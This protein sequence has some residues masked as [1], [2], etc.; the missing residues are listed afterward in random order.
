MRGHERT[1][2]DT[3]EHD[4]NNT[5]EIMT[6]N[7][8]KGEG[9]L[10]KKQHVLS[11]IQRREVCNPTL[12]NQL[13]N[14]SFRYTHLG[15][16]RFPLVPVGSVPSPTSRSRSALGDVNPWPLRRP[17][18]PPRRPP[19][20]FSVPAPAP[21][22]GT[23]GCLAG[24][25]H[26]YNGRRAIRLDRRRAMPSPRRR[27]DGRRYREGSSCGGFGT[28]F[29]TGCGAGCGAGYRCEEGVRRE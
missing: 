9:D 10:I 4:Q 26:R 8:K 27:W 17:R 18:R 23:V 24:A 13:T 2:E 28:G 15:R 25:S 21:R 3:R 1:W 12:I 20:L 16:A 14:T 11:I 6:E 19:R 29:G 7:G 22:V 5:T